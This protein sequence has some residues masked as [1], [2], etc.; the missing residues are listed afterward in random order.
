MHKKKIKRI[1]EEEEKVI[2]AKQIYSVEKEVNI[3][4]ISNWKNK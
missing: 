2:G 4:K 3:N 1:I